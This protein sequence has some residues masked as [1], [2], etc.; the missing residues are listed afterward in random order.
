MG[1]SFVVMNY[2]SSVCAWGALYRMLRRRTGR[3]K[4]ARA[5]EP[6]AASSGTHLR[7][8]STQLPVSATEPGALSGYVPAQT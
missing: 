4:T 2:L 5:A 1:H 7:P 3:D 6:S 8:A